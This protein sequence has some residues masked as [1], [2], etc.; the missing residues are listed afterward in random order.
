MVPLVHGTPVSLE[1]VV[2]AVA[3]NR[4]TESCRQAG[5]AVAKPILAV[6]RLTF[7]GI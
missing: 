2:T 3:V 1:G 7:I 5:K 4:S 6:R